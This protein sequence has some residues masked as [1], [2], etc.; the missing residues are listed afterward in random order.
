[1]LVKFKNKI[2]EGIT[3]LI[4]PGEQQDQENSLEKKINSAGHQEGDRVWVYVEDK[5]C[6]GCIRYIG[7]VP[8][9]KE[10]YAGIELVSLLYLN[11]TLYSI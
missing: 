2:V 6:A 5:L 1:M 11:F 8:G 9:G 7:R 4:A 10:T 3:S